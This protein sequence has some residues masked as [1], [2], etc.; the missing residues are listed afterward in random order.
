M[1]ITHTHSYQLSVITV[2]GAGTQ[3]FRAR[4]KGTETFGEERKVKKDD[5]TARS[6]FN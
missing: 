4:L 2:S 3:D 5:G 1:S 6:L